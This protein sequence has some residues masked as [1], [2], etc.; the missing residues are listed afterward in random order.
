MAVGRCEHPPFDR[1][2][3]FVVAD[4]ELRAA[5][6]VLPTARRVHE[7]LVSEIHQGVEHEPVVAVDRDGEAD[8]GPGRVVHLVHVGYEGRI[9]F[10]RV[11]EPA[12]T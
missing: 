7:L 12:Q 2:G 11:A 3:A 4:D 10:R 5:Q 9:G 8:A 1:D 6:C